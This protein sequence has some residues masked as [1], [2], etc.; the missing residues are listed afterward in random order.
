MTFLEEIISQGLENP[1]RVFLTVII[2]GPTTYCIALAIYRLYFHPLAHIPGPKL[3]ALTSWYEFYYDVVRPGRYVFKIRE[4]HKQYGPILRVS[5]REI[6]VADLS[7]LPQIYPPTST[8]TS[9]NSSHKRNKDI[10]QTRGLDVGMSTSGSIPHDLHRLR[11]DALTPFFGRENVSGFTSVIETKIEK[12]E[13]HLASAYESK[14]LIN[15]SDLYYA[16]AR[17]IV[18]S[19]SFGLE[20]QYLDSEDA[21][22]ELRESMTSLLQGV[23]ISRHFHAYFRATRLLP[24]CIARRSISPG[25]Q[26]MR[27]L[28]LMVKEAVDEVMSAKQKTSATTGTQKRSITSSLLSS[29]IL[30][31]VEKSPARLHSEGT[32]LI[33]AGTES[34]AKVLTTTTY[35][36][37]ANPPILSRLRAELSTST[38][39][40]A[41]TLQRLPYLSAC[42][43]EGNR[44]S[45]GLTGRNARIAPSSDLHYKSYKIPSGT[46]IS[47]TTLCI[48]TNETVF[49][50]PW[51]FDP[52]R[53]LGEE[54][55]ARQKYQYGFGKGA[56]RCLG[57]ELAN[58]EV[59]LTVARM[60]MG[61]YE[62]EL[63]ETWEED[64]VF[65]HDFQ[66]AHPWLGSKG[67]RVLVKGKKGLSE[68]G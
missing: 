4:L 24:A 10:Q 54:G 29:P 13:T 11:R 52:Q 23:K 22:A 60:V 34:T 40:T 9:S 33:L 18:F 19:Y 37:L 32:M 35:Y 51:T 43:S 39:H 50:N 16:L 14:N 44:L 5:P 17:D 30:P 62:L 65:R 68:R 2:I 26:K 15:L 27:E 46:P 20:S 6:H 21:A 66:V 25:V 41:S 12:L 61:G 57:M 63:F 58:A 31:M 36:L 1:T 38:P 47:T 53:W 56:R 42:I 67:V 28:A 49:P 55:K 64:V 7:F 3:A 8:T 59:F 45:F 48:H